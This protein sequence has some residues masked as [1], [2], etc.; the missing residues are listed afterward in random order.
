[1]RKSALELT[2]PKSACPLAIIAVSFLSD[3]VGEF[4]NEAPSSFCI[5]LKASSRQP[6][7]KGT[8]EFADGIPSFVRHAQRGSSQM[9]PP[10]KQAHAS[11]L[12]RAGS[13]PQYTAFHLRLSVYPFQN[14][15]PYFTADYFVPAVSPNQTVGGWVPLGFSINKP[16]DNF[17]FRGNAYNVNAEWNETN[18]SAGC[19]N[20]S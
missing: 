18:N 13:L 14:P 20:I 17:T 6:I 7:R 8:G 9:R 10:C 16:G 4:Q 15:P 2:T 19:F 12:V 1:V 5:L 3:T 11:A